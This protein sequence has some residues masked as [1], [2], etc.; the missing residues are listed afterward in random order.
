MEKIEKLENGNIAIDDVEF[1]PVSQK[2]NEKRGNKSIQDFC[3]ENRCWA[4]R[5]ACGMWYAYANRP[6]LFTLGLFALVPGNWVGRLSS[7]LSQEMRTLNMVHT[8]S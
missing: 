6:H 2:V 4:A 7:V 8:L 3:R 1:A 5:D